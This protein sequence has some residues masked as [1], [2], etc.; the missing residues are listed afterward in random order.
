MPLIAQLG[1]N[2]GIILLIWIIQYCK[3]IRK[4]FDEYV[5]KDLF[6]EK[7]NYY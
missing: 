6:S 1:R 7:L 3:G 4:I 2:I 5:G